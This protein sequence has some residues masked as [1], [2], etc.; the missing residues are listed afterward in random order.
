MNISRITTLRLIL[1][2]TLSLGHTALGGPGEDDPNHNNGRRKVSPPSDRDKTDAQNCMIQ[3]GKDLDAA[4]VAR[5]PREEIDLLRVRHRMALCKYIALGIK[6]A[7]L[8]GLEDQ[9]RGPE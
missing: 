9:K 4:K 7:A 8:E 5:R 3:T 1:S 6:K 2:F